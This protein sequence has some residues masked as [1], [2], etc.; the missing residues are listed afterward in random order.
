[1]FMHAPKVISSQQGLGLNTD[2]V[3]EYVSDDLAVTAEIWKENIE[4]WRESG[5]IIAQKGYKWV[6]R[7]ETGRPYI[8]TKIYDD[9]ANLVG[10]YCD[11]SNQVLRVNNG[12]ECRHMYL[13]VW[14][15][16]GLSPIVL[17][18]NELLDAL[19]AHYI[20]ELDAGEAINAA[21][22]VVNILNL[23]AKELNF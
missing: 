6:T 23:N 14:Q 11:I 16:P 2:M 20:T 9:S 7:W 1:M 13:D 8:I 15:T 18:E 5:T 17:D 12:F 3:I 19:D 22:V 4:P 10:I 21:I